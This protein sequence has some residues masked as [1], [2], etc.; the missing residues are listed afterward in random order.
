MTQLQTLKI[1][2]NAGSLKVLTSDASG[3]GTWQTP[4]GGTDGTAFAFFMA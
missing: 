3:N 4:S 1:T 2:A